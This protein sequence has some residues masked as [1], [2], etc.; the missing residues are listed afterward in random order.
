[1]FNC[2]NKLETLRKKGIQEKIYKRML[3]SCGYQGSD[4]SLYAPKASVDAINLSMTFWK[5]GHQV[6]FY[7]SCRKNG[8]LFEDIDEDISLVVELV[9]NREWQETVN[10]NNVLDLLE[11]HIKAL[12][13]DDVQRKGSII[14]YVFAY[15]KGTE[16]VSKMHMYTKEIDSLDEEEDT[17]NLFESMKKSIQE[18]LTEKGIQNF[19]VEL[20]ADLR[21]VKVN[22]KHKLY[23]H[24]IEIKS[25]YREGISEWEDIAIRIIV[26]YWEMLTT[27]DGYINRF[28]DDL[29]NDFYDICISRQNKRISITAYNEGEKYQ[30]D[31]SISTDA[32][33]TDSM[34]GHEFERFCAEILTENGFDRVYVTQGSGDQGVDVIAHK[35]GVKYAV[36]CKCHSSDIGNKAVQEV[37]AGKDF[38]D[39]HVG[40]VLTN[41]YF[42]KSA[43]ELAKKN[44]VLLWDRKKLLEL[45]TNADNCQ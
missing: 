45:I 3:N 26:L 2:A 19:E 4:V 42:T 10:E 23:K 12:N 38:Y 44:G 37:Y 27:K 24:I 17:E 13:F 43:I 22:V 34:E 33:K 16:F 20:A 31:I 29:E 21:A 25:F 6:H 40:V 9:C 28:V 32:E 18:T 14:P 8:I 5:D 30:V 15:R 36:Q 1:M 11:N 41:R 7:I 39:C 35:D